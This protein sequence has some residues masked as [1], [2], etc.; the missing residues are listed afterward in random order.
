MMRTNFELRKI[1]YVAGRRVVRQILSLA[2][3]ASAVCMP[4][5]VGATH[6]I[7][8]DL[9]YRCLGNNQ[10]EITLTYRRDCFLGDPGTEFEDTAS[11]GFFNLLTNAPLQ[12]VGPNGLFRITRNPIDTATQQFI[13]DCTL[14]GTDLCIEET[15]Y[16][17]TITLQ[18]FAPGYRIVYQR[19][20]RNN[21]LNN[22]DDPTNTGMTL[23]AD[24]SFAAQQACNSSPILGDYPPIYICVNK[25]IAFDFEATD[26]DGD[27]LVFE[28]F[29]PFLGASDNFPQP[30][31]P[32]QPPYTQVT[33]NTP[34]YSLTN[35]LGGVPLTINRFTGYMTGIPNTIGQFLVGVKVFSYRNGV[36]IETTTREWQYNVRACRDQPIADFTVSTELNCDSLTIDF[37]QISLLAEEW[38]W[39]FDYG[40]PA[41]ETSTALNPSYTYPEP[42]FYIVALIVNEPD[43]ICFD[44]AFAT[45]GVFES[46][47]TAGFELDVP[48]C[49]QSIVID[50][51]DLSDD[52]DPDYDITSWQY[53]LSDSTF[54][55]TST[56]QNPQFVIGE[57]A[58]GLNLVLVATSANGCTATFDT[59]FDVNII[60][61]DF[62]GDTVGVCDGDSVALFNDPGGAFTYTWSPTNDLDLTDPSS[63]IAFPNETT[64][65]HVT[66]TDG[67]CEVTDSVVVAVQALPQLAFTTN[68]DCRSLVL[69][70]TNSSTGGFT[71]IWDFGDNQT[72]TLENPSHTY[73]SPGMYIVTLASNDGCDASTSDTITVNIIED[74]VEG[75]STSC[76]AE[77]VTLNPGGNPAYEYQW[78]PEE[79]ILDDPQSA[80]PMVQVDVT[81]TFTVTITDPALPGCSIV[82]VVEVVVPPDFDFGAP[83]D[84]AYCDGPPV[85]LF[86]SNNDLDYEWF[87]LD[88]NLLG[89]GQE[90]LVAPQ[91]ETSYIVVGTDSFGCH[92]EDTIT[93]SPTFFDLTTS[94][95]DTIICFGQDVMISVTNNDPSQILSYQ[96]EPLSDIDS[97]A[98]T[99]TPVVSPEMDQ[100]F[101]VQITNDE[102]GC[103]TTEQ[104]H[105]SVSIFQFEYS[106]SVL[107]CLNEP[108]DL[109]IANLDT[110]GLTFMWTPVEFI[111]PGEENTSSPT[112]MPPETT[113]YT[114]KITDDYGCMTSADITVNISWFTPDSLIIFV[115][116]DTIILG[117]KMFH[118]S[119]N[120]DPTLEFQWS[121]EG[122]EPPSDAPEITANPP[123]EGTYT[124]SVTVTNAD[125]CKLIGQVLGL[126]VL[127]PLCNDMTVFIPDA[128]SPNGDGDND[129]LEVYSNFI[130]SMELRI[131][132][133]WGEEVFVSFDQNM[134]WDG[135]Y[136]GEELSPEVFGYYLRVICIPNKPYFRKGN[137]TLFR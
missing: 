77:A 91:T 124:Y 56:F 35:L 46:A 97:G 107:T 126:R 17:D 113:V 67:L 133:R 123:M 32:P 30:S 4:E 103:V 63:P 108:I 36:L 50:V 118:L 135:T 61:I 11:I 111:T 37:T 80:S 95:N 28:L 90:F 44:T 12:F 39:T 87:D 43:S 104:V 110:T 31:P 106:P 20:C 55:D 99:P 100:T 26:P 132:N 88:L 66:V 33:W 13:N 83:A 2:L 78:T 92:K 73:D 51:L 117:D 74:E 53:I 71:F 16:I 15:N 82:E 45:I 131:Y 109:T 98:N 85:T 89:Q 3:V 60:R 34:P 76:F 65:F 128:F 120:Q 48:T 64:T 25:D 112:V 21:S 29:T 119:T 134:K 52:P 115:D 114:V 23:V 38:Q 122:I 68:T 102:L 19:C 5:F 49:D 116:E 94:G 7:G 57:T 42:G 62:K 101:T 69:N 18:P 129:E 1:G 9:R 105:V 84:M 75:A 72:S 41:S 14:A 59:T 54:S 86:G 121:G 58:P 127:D 24:L 93:L 79:F 137:I 70:T 27:S 8:G 130:E 6:L 10:Y 47:M 22:V 136:K 81:T 40:N 96:W 125:G